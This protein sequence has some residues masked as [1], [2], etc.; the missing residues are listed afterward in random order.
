MSHP[1]IVIVIYVFLGLI[2]DKYLMSDLGEALNNDKLYCARVEHV[3]INFL[4]KGII[5][6][7]WPFMIAYRFLCW[8]LIDKVN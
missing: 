8:L 4:V 6:L 5:V 7:I 3:A 1:T 2:Y